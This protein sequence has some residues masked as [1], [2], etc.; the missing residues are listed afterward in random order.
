MKNSLKFYEDYKKLCM[1]NLQNVLKGKD[2]KD[3][4]MAK[5]LKLTLKNGTQEEKEYLCILIYIMF[6]ESTHDG[7]SVYDSTFTRARNYLLESNSLL[8]EQLKKDRKLRIDS[9]ML[10][11]IQDI[12]SNNKDKVFHGNKITNIK[13]YKKLFIGLEKI[14]RDKGLIIK[15]FAIL[16]G[17]TYPVYN[18]H[19]YNNYPSLSLKVLDTI[20]KSLG[21][22]EEEIINYVKVK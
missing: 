1:S 11:V 2:L 5:T 10:N 8:F 18:G 22:T 3:I 17:I 9:Y 6:K 14:R 15:D 21:M 4:Q 19:L 13:E 12:E 16:L 7:L 20:T